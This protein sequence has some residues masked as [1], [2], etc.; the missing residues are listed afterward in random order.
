MAQQSLLMTVS[1]ED[2]HSCLTPIPDRRF[3]EE[4]TRPLTGR[5]VWYDLVSPLMRHV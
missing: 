3:R 2:T 1:G 5:R 4:K